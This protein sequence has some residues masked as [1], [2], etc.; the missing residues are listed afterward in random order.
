MFIDIQVLD[1]WEQVKG[2]EEAQELTMAKFGDL[3]KKVMSL[4]QSSECER[5]EITRD[6]AATVVKLGA[7]CTGAGRVLPPHLAKKCDEEVRESDRSSSRDDFLDDNHR[8]TTN[9]NAKHRFEAISHNLEKY[10]RAIPYMVG[11]MRI[12]MQSP[13]SPGAQVDLKLRS[14]VCGMVNV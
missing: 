14:K 2:W 12:L 7:K 8:L 11:S 4:V 10:A 13:R 3:L 6:D 9:T 1:I 5:L